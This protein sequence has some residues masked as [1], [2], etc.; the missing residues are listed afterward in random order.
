MDKKKGLYLINIVFSIILMITVVV[1]MKMSTTTPSQADQI[2]EAH[3]HTSGTVQGHTDDDGQQLDQTQSDTHKD[4][5]HEEIVTLTDQFMDTLVQAVDDD[6]KV[7]HFDHIDDLVD[8][9]ASISTHEIA[10]TFIGYYYK[11]KNDG[12]YIIPTE[13]PPWFM[14]DQP[15]DVVQLNQDQ[16]QLA[17]TNETDFYGTYTIELELTY[18][19]GWKITE[20]T[21][22]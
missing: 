3:E 2:K 5:S 18:Q 14:A 6:Y 12:L 19:D 9:L 15:Y 22:S 4:I 13:T 16:V 1:F 8:E 20:I 21:H 17:Q 11:D 7:I 10:Q